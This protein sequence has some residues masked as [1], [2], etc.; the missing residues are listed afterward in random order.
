MEKNVCNR[1]HAHRSTGVTGV[2][3]RCSIDLELQRQLFAFRKFSSSR[4][5]VGVVSGI[6]RIE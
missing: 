5:V 3:L 6:I 1:G 4:V 2:C